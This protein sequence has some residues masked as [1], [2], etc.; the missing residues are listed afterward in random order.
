FCRRAR[1]GCRAVFHFLFHRD[2]LAR[3]PCSDRYRGSP[4]HCPASKPRSLFG[5]LSCADHARRSLL[6]FRRYGLD[7]PLCAHLP[8]G[9]ERRM[10][11]WYPPRTIVRAFLALLALLGLTIGFA[12]LRLG[13]FNTPLALTI[14]TMKALIVAAIFMELRERASLTIAFAGAGFF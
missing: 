5:S 9:T 10:T 13:S 8:A 3:D 2:R 7:I 14:A 1:Q 11:S 4:R 6:A 12:Y